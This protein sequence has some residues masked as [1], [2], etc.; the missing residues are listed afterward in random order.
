MWCGIQLAWINVLCMFSFCLK[1]QVKDHLEISFYD[2][3]YHVWVKL[4]IKVKE[5]L[6]YMQN[7]KI[8][9]VIKSFLLFF[10][11]ERDKFLLFF[12]V[13]LNYMIPICLPFSPGSCETCP[14]KRIPQWTLWTSHQLPSK[15]TLPPGLWD[16][17][18]GG[19]PVSS[20]DCLHT[21][22]ELAPSPEFSQ[23][24][25]PL[26]FAWDTNLLNMQ[27]RVVGLQC[28]NQEGS[29]LA[30]LSLLPCC[31]SDQWVFRVYFL[32]QLGSYGEHWEEHVSFVLM[33]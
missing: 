17:I 7:F 31:P 10:K 18:T 15:E 29:W 30:F 25:S 14:V 33:E 8:S 1:N 23:P 26:L 3:S 21:G 24:S 4:D 6:Y 16:H 5:G 13:V 22:K 28:W 9:F 11:G 20:R 12:G 2:Y 27:L 32:P 19:G